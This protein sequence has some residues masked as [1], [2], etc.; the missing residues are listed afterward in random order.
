[1]VTYAKPQQTKKGESERLTL[2]GDQIKFIHLN[3]T[4]VVHVSSF[5]R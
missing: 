2:G 4:R 3:W 1:M 5:E